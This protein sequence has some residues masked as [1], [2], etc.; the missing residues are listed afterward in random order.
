MAGEEIGAD[1]QA[2]AL[3]AIKKHEATIQRAILNARVGDLVEPRQDVS[4]QLGIAPVY[5]DA[6]GGLWVDGPAG[7]DGSP[8]LRK[9][10]DTRHAG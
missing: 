3:A 5:A 10:F 8:T 9:I 1:A 6:A 4:R 7:A 2:A